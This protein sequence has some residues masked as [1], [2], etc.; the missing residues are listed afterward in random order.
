MVKVGQTLHIEVQYDPLGE[1]GVLYFI[2]FHQHSHE[3]RLH[4]LTKQRALLGGVVVGVVRR[5]APEGPIQQNDQ[6]RS[7]LAREG[8]VWPNRSAWCALL[9]WIPPVWWNTTKY[10]DDHSSTSVRPEWTV[11]LTC[12]IPIGTMTSF[13][14]HA[15]KSHAVCVSD[16]RGV[17]LT[18]VVVTR[19]EIGGS[20]TRRRRG[21]R[22]RRPHGSARAAL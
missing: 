1:P 14:K 21:A 10:Y 6:I 19:V 15:I 5:G 2:G 17:T 13:R 12:T 9:H 11:P 16:G 8:P 18:G 20:A 22:R 3:V 7:N 4:T